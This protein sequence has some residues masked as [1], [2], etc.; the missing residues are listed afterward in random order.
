[1]NGSDKRT[2]ICEHCG[3]RNDATIYDRCMKC[4]ADPGK[5]ISGDIEADGMTKKVAGSFSESNKPMRGG[6]I[7]D[8]LKV[9]AFFYIIGSIFGALA[10]FL[11]YG[12]RESIDIFGSST[13]KIDLPATV[14]AG[15]VLI[16][17]LA[18]GLVLLLIGHMAEFLWDIRQATRAV[19]VSMGEPE[20]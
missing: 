15:G 17:G 4:G 16:Q 18:V 20:G 3:T 10:I 8:W 6:A 12:F 5:T 9:L 7:V 1:M 14:A 19:A 13:T 11:H 2:W